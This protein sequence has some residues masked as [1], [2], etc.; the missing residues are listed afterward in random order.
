MDLKALFANINFGQEVWGNTIESYVIALIVFLAF[1]IVFKIVQWVILAKLSRLA[2]KTETDIDDTLIQIVKSLRPQ[3]YY[4][5]AFWLATK[6]L[7]FS[8]FVTKIINAVLLAWVVYQVIIGVQ[9]LIDYII[10]KKFAGDSEED[11]TAGIVNF[12]SGLAKA[13]L[14]VVGL[15]MVL[16]NL[17][18]NVTSLMAGLGIG[19]LAIAFALQ[20]V[21]ADLF[22]AFSIYLDKPFKVGDYVVVGEHS[23]TV[24]KIGIKSTRIK[25]IHGEEIVISNQELTSAR[26]QNFK[27]L[28][29]R[30][31]SSSFGVT[32]DTP[33]AKLQ[34]IPDIVQKIIDDEQGVRFN[35]VFF[36]AF[37]DSA[38]MFDLV[39][40]VESSEY[41]VY[42]AAQQNMN[43]K[44]KQMFEKEGIDMAYPTQTLYIKK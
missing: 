7:I 41:S 11:G 43:L 12:M 4:F 18:I 34:K 33:N 15:L 38:L 16:S 22:S 23:G 6:T 1:V 13:G 3:F 20:N 8:A 17:G 44:I 21:F 26:V 37:A 10:T 42:L 30:R 24:R 14:W 35:R 19:G 28:E 31:I 32:Y 9:I 36:T 40:Y 2:E 29:E 25:S 39:Y 5:L 27:K